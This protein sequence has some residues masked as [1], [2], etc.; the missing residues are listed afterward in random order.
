EGAEDAFLGRR[1]L[2]PDL[3]AGGKVVTPPIADGVA[4]TKRRTS[5]LDG[6][7]VLVVPGLRGS[8]PGHWQARRVAAPRPFPPAEPAD[9]ATPDLNR[10]AASVATAI[11][12]C[13]APPLVVAH[14]Y[15][16]LAAIRAGYLFERGI[17]GALL[18][19]PSDPDRFGA[20]KQLPI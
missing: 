9:V 18:V 11:D 10:W 16:C 7:P 19:A 4:A 2:R 6:R 1:P 20:L 5:V 3:Q 15:G 14:G 12:G 8:G 17:A 13:D